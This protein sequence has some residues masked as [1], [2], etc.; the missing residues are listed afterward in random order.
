MRVGARV[1]KRSRTRP[2]AMAWL[3]LIAT[4][5]MSRR[6]RAQQTCVDGE[7]LDDV[8]QT[9]LPCAQGTY[10]TVSGTNSVCT[11]CGAG[12]YATG[13]TATCEYAIASDCSGIDWQDTILATYT[14]GT[15]DGT[16]LVGT[17]TF[18][19]GGAAFLS[20]TPGPCVFP[21]ETGGNAATMS[22]S[23][24]PSITTAGVYSVA[25]DA[26][27][28]PAAIATGCGPALVSMA[29]AVTCTWGGGQ[30]TCQQCATGTECASETSTIP[31]PC[32]VG[33]Y[34]DVAGELCK[35][36]PA[37]YA[38]A[39]AST[40]DPTIC[41]KGSASAAGSTA[42][43]VCDPGT[44]AALDGAGVCEAC[45]AGYI[46]ENQGTHTPTICAAGSAAAE[47]SSVCIVCDAGTYSPVAGTAVCAACP[48][49][50]KCTNSGTIS[51]VICAAGS[52]AEEGSTL[53]TPCGVGTYQDEAG[54]GECKSCPPGKSCPTVGL[55]AYVECGVGTYSGYTLQS[56]A[57]DV[58][59]DPTDASRQPVASSGA[60][61]L[62]CPKGYSCAVAGEAPKLCEIGE[63]AL[64]DGAT[65]CDDC[66]AGS[67]CPTP[68]FKG[69][70]ALGS[71]SVGNAISCSPCDAG[72]YCTDITKNSQRKC[73]IGYFSFGGTVSACTKCPAGRKC[74]A[75][76]GSLNADC[77]SGTFSDGGQTGC[78]YCPPGMYCDDVTSSA[79]Q[80][81]CGAGTYSGGGQTSCTSC[82][83]GTYGTLVEAVSLDDCTKCPRGMYSAEVGASTSD[84]CLVCP[85][86]TYCP[87][88]GNTEAQPCAEGTGTFGAVGQ[89]AC[90]LAPPPPAPPPAPPPSPPPPVPPS[91]PPVTANI[92]SPEITLRLDGSVA[93]WTSTK[94]DTF[95][96]GIA[97]SIGDGTTADDIDV[98]GITQGSVI[99]AFWVTTPAMQPASYG[100]VWNQT[101]LTMTLDK[102]SAAVTANTLSVGATILNPPAINCAPG[103]YVSA[104]SVCALCATG[105]YSAEYNA[106]ACTPCARG[107]EAPV[108][109]TT[110]C[111]P[112][113]AGSVAQTTGV[114]SCS[115]CP[116]GMK[117]PLTGQFEC[118]S[119]DDN[120][121]A[122]SFG[123]VACTACPSGTVSG[124]PAWIGET[125]R[126]RA[127]GQL[128]V[129]VQEAIDHVRC[130]P[131]ATYEIPAAA[132]PPP[133]R[134]ETDKTSWTVAGISTLAY[135]IVV[136]YISRRIWDREKLTLRFAEDDIFMDLITPV[137][138]NSFLTR[139]TMRE[140]EVDDMAYAADA[141]RNGK[142]D[143]AKLI[144]KRITA[145]NPN[146]VDAIH[147]LA[148][149][150]ALTGEV[151]FARALAQRACSLAAT[152]QR[153]IALGNI[154]YQEGQMSKA[155]TAYAL[156]I[157]RDPVSAIGHF[158]SATAAFHMGDYTNARLGYLAALDRE[159][160]YF[161]C[162][163]NLAI[164]MEAQGSVAEAKEWM[165]RAVD[166]RP[167]DT[168]AQYALA[169]LYVKLGQWVKAE[170]QFKAILNIDG[171]HAKSKVKLGNLAFRRGQHQRAAALYLLAIE[172]D[173]MDVEALTNLAMLDWCKGA[174]TSCNEQLRLALTI[175]PDYYP[176]LY[177]LAVTRLSQGRV[178]DSV[179][180]Y[181]RALE[182]ANNSPF[183]KT[184]MF[185]L[186]MALAE[187]DELADNEVPPEYTPNNIEYQLLK[188]A[189]M[190][191]QTDDGRS[192][193]SG[194]TLKSSRVGSSNHLAT[195]V[196]TVETGAANKT[197]ATNVPSPLDE[198]ALRSNMQR[199]Y[200]AVVFISDAVKFPARLGD[201]AHDDTLVIVYEHDANSVTL[202]KNLID[203]ATE[204][205]TSAAGLQEVDR[206]GIV[207][208][209]IP[210][211]ICL[212][213]DVVITHKTTTQPGDVSDFL[214]GLNK[215]L[216]RAQWRGKRLDFLTL[217]YALEQNVALLRAI[218]Y[219]HGFE[220]EVSCS[221]KMESPEIYA[222]RDEQVNTTKGADGGPRA[223]V[224]YFD[225]TPLKTWAS[226]PQAARRHKVIPDA[227]REGLV[228]IEDT[229]ANTKLTWR[230]VG[231]ATMSLTP[232]QK[233]AMEDVSIQLPAPALAP[234]ETVR[235]AARRARVQTVASG[236]AVNTVD[237]EILSEM[238]AVKFKQ[239]AT[240][241]FF[242]KEIAAEIGVDARRVR[243]R[244][245]NEI[246]DSIT[247]RITERKDGHDGGASLASMVK[248]LQ[249]GADQNYL[250]IDESFGQ[251]AVAGVFWPNGSD[252]DGDTTN[253]D[254]DDGVSEI[255][256]TDDTRVSH[257][258]NATPAS[259]DDSVFEEFDVSDAFMAKPRG[260]SSLA[261]SQK[262]LEP[263]IVAQ[264][265]L[266]EPSTRAHE[267]IDIEY[268]DAP[269]KIARGDEAVEFE[270][271]RARTPNWDVDANVRNLRKYESTGIWD[272][273]L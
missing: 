77:T 210:G 149:A 110:F 176:A 127:D 96:A 2:F 139:G 147:G 146:H 94:E 271:A 198:R 124:D 130:I 186:G 112:C 250:V 98:I 204:E 239:H 157:R 188:M 6:V 232:R 174:S 126:M 248:H 25:C 208:P 27:T 22:L 17:C 86:N 63:I 103:S 261:V 169:L 88:E 155:S 255:S 106:V 1:W 36:C 195:T 150:Y 120:F 129:E 272:T 79:A 183:V 241:V 97:A 242:C 166:V 164:V 9:C 58:P 173:P 228:A 140:Y 167:T 211:G 28:Q 141:M 26:T 218:K 131:D 113:A 264:Q 46:C 192:V 216:G 83:A 35:I 225:M 31:V 93:G 196:K 249:D 203:K 240:Q 181:R 14:D 38:C 41:S 16:Q 39:F 132:P 219:E 3:W 251:I 87:D 235:A 209:T 48:S 119:C 180:Y 136:G 105:S 95:K 144:Y 170:T 269:S 152:S 148:I 23:C 75:I 270:R 69:A 50:Y 12:S 260:G 229:E 243:V 116:R 159:P 215:L 33:K 123:S 258:E 10:S 81:I 80:Y 244:S 128:S 74:P 56:N 267:F 254:A 247:I 262:A 145:R 263:T 37:G 76:D 222:L 220:C 161:K 7:Y 70:C 18:T 55:D 206:I 175:K 212:G 178:E 265:P 82:P 197:T 230:T 231:K 102:L 66:P 104:P 111:S 121:F 193:K 194:R 190:K 182:C 19:T 108:T 142:I 187:L 202:C 158:N 171:K 191:L 266:D 47:G 60:A 34:N 137:M 67:Y 52:F 189:A 72:R 99:V 8:S 78:T 224:A 199:V 5:A 259:V 73:E 151:K 100:G 57:F 138:D 163:F 221:D 65:A 125:P 85:V 122:S 51:P 237:I 15:Y 246:V 172:N 115:S 45:P 160:H 54:Q 4:L 207:C 109:G 179:R 134:R 252:G 238:P 257:D 213:K 273:R 162:M 177:N 143:E 165:K 153:Q 89:T 256:S 200:P 61:C 168:R 156:A 42:C 268:N 84:V 185:N 21:V 133:G 40:V 71:F 201:S 118:I 234:K 226:L 245:V 59:Y 101:Y 68:I 91:P 236:L 11:Q 253:A 107:S 13:P 49:G 44:Y 117:Q 53:C 62:P 92:K 205:L 24:V 135:L 223:C 233:L 217:D 184:Q 29:T 214:K 30:S 227:A 43:T 20:E 64:A 32:A 154:C 114:S 90:G